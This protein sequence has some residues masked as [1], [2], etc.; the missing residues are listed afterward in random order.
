MTLKRK[1]SLSRTIR[2]WLA[3]LLL[4]AFMMS[5]PKS[6]VGKLNLGSYGKLQGRIFQLAQDCDSGGDVGQGISGRHLGTG[7]L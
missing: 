4:K 1:R 6:T 3:H 7:G 5:F 2:K